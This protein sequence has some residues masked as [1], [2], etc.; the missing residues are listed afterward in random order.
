M[1]ADGNNPQTGTFFRRDALGQVKEIGPVTNGENGRNRSVQVHLSC[2]SIG[3][4]SDCVSLFLVKW[5]QGSLLRSRNKW[6]K[7]LDI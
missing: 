1:F 7:L 4:F 6:R 2:D 3:M 5:T